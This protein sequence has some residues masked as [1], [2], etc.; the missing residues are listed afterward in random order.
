ML[1][2][3]IATLALTV[4]FVSVAKADGGEYPMPVQQTFGTEVN[5]A[6]MKS[7]GVNTSTF[8][9]NTGESTNVGT[10]KTEASAIQGKTSQ[11]VSEV[12]IITNQ[13][14]EGVN[15]VTLQLKPVKLTGEVEPMP[16]ETPVVKPVPAQ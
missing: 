14:V 8:N 3:L 9:P 10:F 13:T 2:T 16:V 11:E 12:K 5:A 4:S 1:K 15:E 6:Q 7:E